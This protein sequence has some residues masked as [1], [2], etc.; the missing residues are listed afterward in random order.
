MGR[1]PSAAINTAVHPVNGSVGTGGLGNL[2]CKGCRIRHKLCERR[3]GLTGS[4][5]GSTAVIL[6][7]DDTIWVRRS[8]ACVGSRAWTRTWARRGVLIGSR[9]WARSRARSGA[10]AG[11]RCVVW[12]TVWRGTR[13]LVT[14]R[15]VVIIVTVIAGIVWLVGW[16]GALVVR[17]GALLA[18][19]GTL[20]ARWGTLVARW[21]SRSLGAIWV[22]AI[23]AVIA[24]VVLVDLGL[25]NGKD[26]Q[27]LRLH[28]GY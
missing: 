12:L 19:W 7:L 27:R 24:G 25:R 21:G 5:A 10:W 14:V 4:T 28:S 2:F 23:V 3:E 11:R 26:L 16:R 1:S 8:G 15:V 22:V 20:L 6:D 17:R 9:I 18:R 13:S